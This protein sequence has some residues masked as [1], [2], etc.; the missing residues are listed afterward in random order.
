M[1]A[2]KLVK[3][4]VKNKLRYSTRVD[5]H[6]LTIIGEDVVDHIF[7]VD[8]QDYFKCDDIANRNRATTGLKKSVLHF[9]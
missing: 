2:S 8:H 9:S 3:S 1:L 6:V 4:K 7:Y 5:R